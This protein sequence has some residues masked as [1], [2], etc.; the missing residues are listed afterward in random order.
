MCVFFLKIV[1]HFHDFNDIFMF[2]RR[3][4][5]FLFQSVMPI[6]Q[7]QFVRKKKKNTY[8]KRF[9]C[10]VKGNKESDVVFMFIEKILF[11]SEASQ[12]KKIIIKE[13]PKRRKN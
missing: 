2:V 12:E 6:K 9:E 4:F 13:K 8:T 5:Q 7:V 1:N 10:I 3:P 11:N